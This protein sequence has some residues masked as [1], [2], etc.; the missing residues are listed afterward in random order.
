MSQPVVDM[1]AALR[2]LRRVPGPMKALIRRHGAPPLSKTRNSFASLGRAIVSQQLSGKAADTIYGRFLALYPRRR[3][4]R[5][6]ELL[7]TPIETLRGAGLSRAK[8]S[9]LHDLA[10]KFQD[11]TVIPRRFVHMDEDGLRAMLTQVKGI[12]PWS[13]DMFLIFGLMRPDVLPVGDLGVRKGV[14]AYF[15]TEALPDAEEMTALSEGWRPYRSVA[16]WYMWRVVE[17]GLP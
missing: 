4:P 3:F 6:D 8:A 16:S 17:E 9:S 1:P 10:A 15:G 7:A 5:P 14:Q 11:G 12:G 2:H 13:V